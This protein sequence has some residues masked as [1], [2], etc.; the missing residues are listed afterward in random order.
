MSTPAARDNHPTPPAAR[1]RVVGAAVVG[2]IVEWYDFTLYGQAAALVFSQL[3]FPSFSPL[4]GTAA[5][6]ATYAVGFLARPLGGLVFSHFGDRIGRRPMLVLTLCLMGVAT[7]LIGFL[8]TYAAVGVWAPVLL[9]VL[10]LLQGAGAG[11]EYAG[12]VVMVAEH[13]GARRRGLAAAVPAAGTFVGILLATGTATLVSRLPESALLSWGWRVPF[14]CS[15]VVVAVG[16]YLR[17]RVLE[18]PE[19]E[20]VK[21]SGDEHR[22]P[23]ARLL[24]TQPRRVLLAMGTNFALNGYSYVLQVFFLTYIT[25]Q[26]GMAKS[27]G[28]TGLFIASAVAIV[29]I[30]LFGALSD[31]VG[32]RTV[33]LAGAVFATVFSLAFFPLLDTEIPWVIW[34]ALTIGVAVG[35]ASMF[36]AQGSFYAELFDTRSRYSGIAFVR[37]V[38]GAL[39]GGPTPFLATAL[40]A[41]ASGSP[42]PIAGYM[43]FTTVVSAVCAAL[44]P[45]TH[46]RGSRT[47]ARTAEEVAS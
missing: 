1:R 21:D 20:S 41:V 42:W 29:T 25:T 45:E 24:R 17:R 7:T 47:A 5:A 38:T 31:R 44:L 8:P 16:I 30:P 37:E 46:P 9:V 11:A 26:L 28:L 40:L 10:R 27:V 18:S 23:L 36:G 22:L 3:F 6:F 12:A 39:I 32:R 34:L 35:A 15:V 13:S 19:F 2:T 43:V 14:W 4:A 33:Y